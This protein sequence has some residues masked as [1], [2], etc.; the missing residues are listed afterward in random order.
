MKTKAFAAV[1]IALAVAGCGGSDNNDSATPS[2]TSGGSASNN[3]G[4]GGSLSSSGSSYLGQTF[5][6]GLSESQQSQA[7]AQKSANPEVKALAQQLTTEVSVINQQIT[8]LSQNNQVTINNTLTAEQQTQLNN[9]NGLSGAELD[10]A[11]VTGLVDAWK[12]LL[13]ATLVEARQGADIQ[14]RQAASANLLAIEQRLAAAQQVLIVLQPPVY[15]MDAFEDGLLEIQLGQLALQKA[16]DARVKQFAQRM[17]DDHTQVNANITALAQQKKI[18][19]PTGLSAE[20]QEIVNTI[21]GFSGADFDKAYMDRNVLTH[22]EDVSKTTIESQQGSDAEIKGLAAQTLPILQAHLQSAQ[23]IAATLQ[24]SALYQLG[25]NVAAEIQ[26][27]QLAQ[28]R[29]TDNQVKTQAQQILATSQQGY[30]QVVQLAQTQNAA[31]PLLIPPAQVPTVL[32]LASK[33]G[34]DFD[35]SVLNLL[36]QQANQSLQLVQSLQTSG[37]AALSNIVVTLTPI[38][39]SAAQLFTTGSGS[40][41]TGATGTGTTGTGTIGTGTTGTGITGTTGTGT[42]GTGATGIGTGTTGTGI[43][44]TGTTG[45][46]GTTG[47]T[48]TGSFGSGTTGTTGT[49]LT[50]TTGSSTGTTGIGTSGTG[51]TGTGSFGSGTTGTTGTGLTGSTTGTTGIGTSGIGTSTGTGIGG[52]TT[53]T[54]TTGFGTTTGIGGIGSSGTGIT[55]TMTGI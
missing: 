55:G 27:A 9:I 42:S 47:T 20:Q 13:A 21:S 25:Q 38:L 45:I 43:T 2:D 30:A 19:L 33:T 28:V 3:T 17:I 5:Q 29:T 49:G 12:N 31:V 41:S 44:G 10:Q 14:I 6:T 51:T 11:Y 7:V 34:A 24:G 35:Q 1:L 32:Q 48:G 39:Q 53:G 50:G 37:D 36:Q 16:S 18:T 26:I 8:Q 40:G 15:L 46:G 22:A 4:G 54:D 23:S 52:G